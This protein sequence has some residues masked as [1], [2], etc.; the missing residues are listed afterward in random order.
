MAWGSSWHV[1]VEAR[2]MVLCGCVVL[3][4]I[5]I[6]SYGAWHGDPEH[7]HPQDQ[8]S[9]PQSLRRSRTGSTNYYERRRQVADQEGSTSPRS[10][11]RTQTSSSH[12]DQEEAQSPRQKSSRGALQRHPTSPRREFS[13]GSLVRGITLPTTGG[14]ISPSPSSRG[15]LLRGITSPTAANAC[16]AVSAGR[17]T[18]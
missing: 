8:R 2:W 10:Q 3:V 18:P 14:A 5:A 17:L 15:S 1:G 16:P 12:E 11:W 4:G 9:V 7:T 6:A 13:R